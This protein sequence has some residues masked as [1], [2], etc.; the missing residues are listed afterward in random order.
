MA[1]AVPDIAPIALPREP[2][3]LATIVGGLVAGAGGLAYGKYLLHTDLGIASLLLAGLCYYAFRSA[4]QGKEITR[5]NEAL[6]AA[7]EHVNSLEGLLPICTSCKRVCD[8]NGYWSQIDTY[9]HHRT[10]AS[11]SHGYCPLCAAKAFEDLGVEIPDR[12]LADLEA[13]NF[14]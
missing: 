4:R 10:N 11:F 6:K 9:L 14:E 3:R 1:A 2:S 12:V 5:V 13:R 7:L 8:E